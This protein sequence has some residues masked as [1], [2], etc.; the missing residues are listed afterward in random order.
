M[1]GFVAIV[2]LDGAPLDRR[3]LDRMT[4]YLAFRGP[5]ARRVHVTRDAGLGHTLLRVTDE[6]ALERQPFTLDGRTWI[7]ADARVD[8][9][10]DLIASLTGRESRT[11]AA[12]AT[13]V[14]L[15]ARAFEAWKDEC[16]THLLGDFAFVV[17]D[18]ARRQL[19]CARDHL[20]VK[21]LFYARVGQTIVIS[22]TLDCVRLHP[23]V[24]NDLNDLAIAD[25]LLFGDNQEHDTTSFRDIRRL[26]PAHCMTWSIA[27]SHCRRYWTLPV[28]EP[29]HFK[30][31]DDYTSC[32]TEL[33]QRA[34]RDRLR[35]GSAGVL[36]SG[37]IDST[38]LAAVAR[39][40]LR[41]RRQGFRL[42]A[43]TSVY[44]ELIPDSERHYAGLA[45]AHLNIPIRFDVRDRETSITHPGEL[46]IRT[47]EPVENPAAFAAGLRFSKDAA[48]R[49]R[50][51]FYG[52]G[53]DNALLYEWHPYLSNL[54]SG[55]RYGRLVRALSYDLVMHPRVPLWT[56]IR[57]FA[58][59][60]T[61]QRDGEF[62]AWLSD[63]LAARYRCRDR[64]EARR[65]RAASHPYRPRGYAAF[66]DAR[67][68]SFFDYFDI[69]GAL[70]HSE[71]RHPFFDLRLLRYMLAVPAMPW[72]RRKL[73]IRR[74]MQ[75]VLPRDVIRRKKTPLA[76]S[77][78][79]TRVARSG[80]PRLVPTPALAS[81]VN[82]E[83]MPSVPASEVEM[84]ALLR[85]LGLN[86]WLDRLSSA[87]SEDHFDNQTHGIVGG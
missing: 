43:F 56:S 31:A 29:I 24:S 71:T 63:R 59:R 79:F 60:R 20:G 23:G 78:D 10:D 80:F 30:R 62:P 64:W 40:L 25:F 37:G 18:E 83:K 77:P 66:S 2:N 76:A 15:I 58:G 51:F 34:T 6:S 4:D 39:D 70:S 9:R 33:V 84:R 3:L 22:N 44:D 42:Q 53:P 13:D 35:T 14:E 55:R 81:Y 38:T 68:Q 19:F 57:Q 8:A 49:T 11:C 26:A 12:D 27:A 21:P 65:R 7:V 28:D 41:E 73:L 82:V 5:D 45:A 61:A 32:F 72:C 46:S 48:T 36:M 54:L 86:Y 52:E 75:G 85:P 1:S 69:T 50:L 74:S 87:R 16:V 67:W 47:A 17:W